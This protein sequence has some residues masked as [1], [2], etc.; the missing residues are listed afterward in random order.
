MPYQNSRN[1]L[2][3][4]VESNVIEEEEK[5][6]E[7]PLPEILI[8]DDNV[9]NLM[10]IEE[11]LKEQY[12]FKYEKANNGQE[13]VEAVRKRIDQGGA[14]FKL[15]LMDLNMPVMDGIQATLA[16]LDYCEQ[17]DSDI[18]PPPIVALTAYNTVETEKE[19][20]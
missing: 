4:E 7:S 12:G 5:A 1:V 10:V 11:T 2:R 14:N 8:A 9:F 6:I 13:A 19:C 20:L 16:I 18:P 17:N 3:S 15:I